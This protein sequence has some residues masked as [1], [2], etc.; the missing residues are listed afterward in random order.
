MGS[1]LLPI[2][3][4]SSV[5]D[6]AETRSLRYVNAQSAPASHIART[7][8]RPMPLVPPVTIATLSRREFFSRLF[9]RLNGRCRHHNIRDVHLQSR[10]STRYFYIISFLHLQGKTM[11]ES[12]IP[13]PSIERLVLSREVPCRLSRPPSKIVSSVTLIMSASRRELLH[14]DVSH[15]HEHSGT[16]KTQTVCLHH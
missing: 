8:A 16:R 5:S 11:L 15:R 10:C 6:S 3:R 13:D 12:N 14:A 7:M 9:S 1:A 2:R 4:T